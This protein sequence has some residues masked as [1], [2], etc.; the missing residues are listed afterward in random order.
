MSRVGKRIH[1]LKENML[2][3]LK[4]L[5]S[6]CYNLILSDVTR[7]EPKVVVEEYTLVQHNIRNSCNIYIPLVNSATKTSVV[8]CAS[9]IVNLTILEIF[10]C[11]VWAFPSITFYQTD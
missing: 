9:N 8:F 10:I 3:W 2:A 1:C 7:P 6:I 11:Q 5:K 4:S